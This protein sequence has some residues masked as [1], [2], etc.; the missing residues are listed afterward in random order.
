MWPLDSS[1]LLFVACCLDRMRD[2]VM[3]DWPL[4]SH[5][6]AVF[7]PLCRWQYFITNGA[8]FF[9][10]QVRFQVQ[11]SLRQFFGEWHYLVEKLHTGTEVHDFNICHMASTGT[12]LEDVTLMFFLNL[13]IVHVVTLL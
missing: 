3:A 2:V 1:F 6:V 4:F 13:G 5:T 8:S 9:P 7:L 11:M 12:K 10:T